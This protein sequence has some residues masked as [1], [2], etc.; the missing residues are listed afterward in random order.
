MGRILHGPR[1]V[2]EALAVQVALAR[3]MGAWPPAGF[4]IGATAVAMQQY[5]GV[6]G[7]MAGFMPASGLHASGST[8]RWDGFMNP[9]VECE[10]AVVLARPL[11]GPCSPEEAAAAVGELMPAVEVVERRGTSEPLAMLADQVFHKSAVLG[12]PLPDWRE[13]DLG[14]L[15]GRMVVDGAERGRGVGA[16]LHGGPMHALAW[17]AGSEEAAAFGGLQAGQV[18]MLGSAIPPVGL[19]GPASVQVSFGTG[20]AEV[21]LV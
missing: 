18:V 2:A 13:L 20:K 9:G 3:R 16:D 21:E 7:P 10:L 12:A 1:S 8:L 15:P 6:S 5:L 4:K 14:K 19:D 11:P 17:L